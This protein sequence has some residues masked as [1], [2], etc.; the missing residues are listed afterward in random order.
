MIVAKGSVNP[1][2]T[3][4]DGYKTLKMAQYYQKLMIVNTFKAALKIKDSICFVP[5]N[6]KLLT[7]SELINYE[8]EFKLIVP[9]SKESWEKSYILQ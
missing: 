7:T 2:Y 9:N 3:Q 4:P 1:V 6:D 8:Q 5:P